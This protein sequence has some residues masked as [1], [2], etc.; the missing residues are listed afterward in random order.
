[1]FNEAAEI[2]SAADIFLFQHGPPL[3]MRS[4]AD[5]L[6]P[7]F[8]TPKVSW[9][10]KGKT[11]ACRYILSYNSILHTVINSLMSSFLYS[12]PLQLIMAKLCCSYTNPG[13]R[14]HVVK[15]PCYIQPATIHCNSAGKS[16]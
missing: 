12:H 13:Y 1:M 11:S 15:P 10:L 8:L 7:I 16:L 14:L 4:A 5:G 6:K 2:M 3:N 9:S